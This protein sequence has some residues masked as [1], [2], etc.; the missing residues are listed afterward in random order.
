MGNLVYARARLSENVPS[1]SAARYA[2]IIDDW[3]MSEFS[4]LLERE[5]PLIEKITNV[6]CRRSGMSADDIEEFTAEV[7][8]R[9]VKNDY[10][11]LRAYERRSRFATYIAAVIRRLLIDYRRHHLGKWHD[12][13]EARRLGRLGIDIER[14][15]LRDGRTVEETL[16]LLRDEHPG[17]TIDEIE[18]IAGV[19]PARIRHKLVPI[20][21]AE[22]IESRGAAD[23]VVHVDTAARISAVV[24]AFIDK[25]PPDEQLIFRLRFDCD[26]TV[27]QISRSLHRDQQVLYRLLYKYFDALRA[28]LTSVGVDAR[29][30]E[31]LIGSD[32]TL[33]DFQLKKRTARPSEGA[34]NEGADRQEDSSS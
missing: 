10:A 27:A 8:L 4:Q 5:L 25:L 23:R 22:S 29:A 31:D 34:E 16:T 30:V 9:L 12:S 2:P 32:S 14:A 18:R 1:S 24:C 33:L 19:L 21:E 3:P 15:I 11:I 28:E 17:V 7:K 26:M 6:I 20:E 13:A